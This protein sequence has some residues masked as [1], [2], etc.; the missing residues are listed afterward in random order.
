MGLG[1]GQAA[2][3]AGKNSFST[4]TLSSS[5]IDNRSQFSA[6]AVT[7][8]AGTSGG[9]AGA[10]KDS[11]DERSTT[12]STIS[13]GSTTI[14]SGDAA[15]QAALGRAAWQLSAWVCWYIPLRLV[16]SM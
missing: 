12:R 3:D 11:G 1:R 9:M 15:S 16:G 7:V 2:I 5:D 10:F 8:S 6:S 14:T 13:A 4:G